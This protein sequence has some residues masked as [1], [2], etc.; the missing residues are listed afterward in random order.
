MMMSVGWR[1]I[2]PAMNSSKL[3]TLRGIS[4]CEIELVALSTR[5]SKNSTG[6][7][8]SMML[9]WASGSRS[10]STVIAPIRVDLPEPVAPETIIMPLVIR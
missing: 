8:H 9:R 5:S 6:S 4:L 7:A 1:R 2:A 10:F 3:F